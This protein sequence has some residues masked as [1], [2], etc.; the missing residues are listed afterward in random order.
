MVLTQGADYALY[1]NAT[2]YLFKSL[3]FN[4]EHDYNPEPVIIDI[5]LDKAGAGA[6][7]VLN[8]LF[9]EVDKYDLAPKSQTELDKLARFLT[10]NP[11]IKVEISGHT[12]DTGTPSYNNTLSL[13]RAQAVVEYLTGHGITRT[14]L[15]QVGHGSTKPLKPND[16]DA[17][18]QVNRRIE[19]RILP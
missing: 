5:S 9:F 18:R 17:N 8:N 4:Y 19:F 10:E 16:S 11:T 1:A 15:V 7:V 6:T 12:D 2:G 3:N 14:R 13:K